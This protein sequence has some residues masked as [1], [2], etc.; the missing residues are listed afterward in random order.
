MT[1]SYKAVFRLTL[2]LLFLFIGS[3]FAQSVAME[4]NRGIPLSISV[5]TAHD[6]VKAGSD[7]RIEVTLTNVT[8]TAIGIES[9][10]LAPYKVLVNASDGST[11]AETGHG[12]KIKEVQQSREKGETISTKIGQSLQPGETK[13]TELV[14]T[15]LYD[16][17]HPGK[18]SIQVERRWEGQKIRSNTLVITI[19]P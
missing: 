1:A 15:D 18:Y 8:T 19:T 11:P 6:V 5:S 3:G 12:R 2:L 9:N 4:R 10:A 14:V 17:S 16:V 7:I 13:T